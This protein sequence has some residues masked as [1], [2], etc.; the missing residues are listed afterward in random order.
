[1]PAVNPKTIIS[2]LWGSQHSDPYY[3]DRDVELHKSLFFNFSIKIIVFNICVGTSAVI[4]YSLGLFYFLYW[5]I[6]DQRNFPVYSEC[7]LQFTNSTLQIKLILMQMII[8]K[9][10]EKSIDVLK[11]I[12]RCTYLN[13]I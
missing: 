10:G 7:V 2:R 12:E 11:G 1:M 3:K 9:K 6:F 8:D 13:N 5:P 4:Y